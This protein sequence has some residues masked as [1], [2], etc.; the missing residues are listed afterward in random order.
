MKYYVKLFKIIYEN[1]NT[2]YRYL[3]LNL[4]LDVEV[5]ILKV[6]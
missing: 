4:G 1:L 2:K 5:L 3:I 6:V